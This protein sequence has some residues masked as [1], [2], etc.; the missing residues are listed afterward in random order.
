VYHSWHGDR[1]QYRAEAGGRTESLPLSWTSL[2]PADP[3][4]ERSAGRAWFRV[5]DL[6]CLV[7]LIAAARQ[8]RG[9]GN[10]DGV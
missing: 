4:V 1:V 7:E 8:P 5:A 3:F 10:E 9:E 6:L 2:A